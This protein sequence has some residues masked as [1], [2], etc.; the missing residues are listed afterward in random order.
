MTCSTAVGR[1][2]AADVL[3]P[4]TQEGSIQKRAKVDRDTTR[5]TD[6]TMKNSLNGATHDQSEHI[7]VLDV[8]G[9]RSRFHMGQSSTRCVQLS[10][11]LY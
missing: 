7:L 10:S 3:K 5:L 8:L 6:S 2:D 1:D 4:W 9:L 11:I